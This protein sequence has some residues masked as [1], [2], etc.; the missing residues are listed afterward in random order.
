MLMPWMLTP[1]LPG[2][3]DTLRGFSGGNRADFGTVPASGLTSLM[4]VMM[5]EGLRIWLKLAIS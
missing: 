5:Y 3:Y 1:K 2:I 4:R